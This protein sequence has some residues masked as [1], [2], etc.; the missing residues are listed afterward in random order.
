M[1]AIRAFFDT[2]RSIAFGDIT[3]AYAPVG[4]PFD[5]T[6]RLIHITNNTDGDMIISTNGVTDHLFVPAHSF[7]LLDLTTNHGQ[8]DSTFVLS[9]ETQ[10]YVKESTASTSGSLYIAAVYGRGQ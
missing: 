6:V 9:K 7:I 4:T 3:G 1:S 5:H 10:F 8:Y 2:L